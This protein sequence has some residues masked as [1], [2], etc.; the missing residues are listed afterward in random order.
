M[1]SIHY[2]VVVRFVFSFYLFILTAH[3]FSIIFMATNTN[4]LSTDVTMES[5]IAEVQNLKAELSDI[6]AGESMHN[7][8]LDERGR[9]RYPHHGPSSRPHNTKIQYFANLPGENFL[10]WRSHS[11]SSRRT[12]D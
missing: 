8:S 7:L 5:L 11:K 1:K 10:A 2:Y 6:Q 3:S 4:N 12:T 9:E